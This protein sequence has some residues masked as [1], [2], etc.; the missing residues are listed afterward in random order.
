MFPED[1]FFSK[2]C[3]DIGA[4]NQDWLILQKDKGE[5]RALL[6]SLEGFSYERCLFWQCGKRQLMDDPLV[7]ACGLR[8]FSAQRSYFS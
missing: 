2:A 1:G 4:K 6:Q 5:T 3:T 8:P 7:D